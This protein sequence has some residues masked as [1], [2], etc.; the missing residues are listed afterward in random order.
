MLEGNRQEALEMLVGMVSRAWWA[1]RALPVSSSSSFVALR[2]QVP[3]CNYNT[4]HSPCLDYDKVLRV[5][6]LLKQHQ[7]ASDTKLEQALALGKCYLS[8]EF[9]LNVLNKFLRDRRPAWRFFLWAAAQSEES[10]Y[11]HNSTT[12]NKMIDILGK[13]KQFQ[14]IWQLVEEMGNRGLITLKTL[15]ISIKAFAGAGQMKKAVRIFDLVTS[16]NTNVN[17]DDFN[18]ILDALSRARLSSEGYIIF[19]KLKPTFPSNPKTYSIVLLGLCRVNN[20]T[21]AMKVWNEMVEQGFKPHVIDCN[22]MLEALFKGKK[23]QEAFKLFHFMLPNANALSYTIVIDALCRENKIEQAL[24]LFDEM[25]DKR[26]APDVA[27]YKCMIIGLGN[28]K[29]LDEAYQMLEGMKEPHIGVYNALI[30]VMVNLRRPDEANQLFHKMIKNGCEPI[31]HTYVMLMQVNFGVRMGRKG[32]CHDVNF[33]TVFVGGLIKE[34]RSQEASKYLESIIYKGIRPPRFDYNKFLGDFSSSHDGLNIFEEVAEKMR[35]AGK[36][37]ISDVFLRY[38]QKMTTRDKRRR[39]MV[40]EA[41]RTGLILLLAI[42]KTC[43]RHYTP[44]GIQPMSSI[45]LDENSDYMQGASDDNSENLEVG[46]ELSKRVCSDNK[47]P[48]DMQSWIGRV[49]YPSAG[50]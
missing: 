31:M 5:A 33:H 16:C 9:V 46:P 47:L 37:D 34:G 28:A 36:L 20:V 39:K 35:Q 21:Q 42:C 10:G 38:S 18:F 4:D 48:R 49:L 26:W 50:S 40:T 2:M 17:V 25:K 43:T 29:R 41:G 1:L 22:A 19:K 44:L 45:A 14:T 7:F 24:K 27:V 6:E 11:N 3:A 15:E 32:S 12:Y 23:H 13:T 8:H 30:K